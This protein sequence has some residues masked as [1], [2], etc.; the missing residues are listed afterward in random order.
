MKCC[1][2]VE[3][4]PE[5]HEKSKILTKTEWRTRNLQ[6]SVGSGYGIADAG[7]GTEPHLC[8]YTHLWEF[9]QFQVHESLV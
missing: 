1:H 7:N 9:S 2:R 6:K 4:I 3:L 5:A 8:V